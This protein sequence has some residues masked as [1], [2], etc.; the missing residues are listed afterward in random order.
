MFIALFIK[1]FNYRDFHLCNNAN[2][3]FYPSQ[4]NSIANIL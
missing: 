3:F 2:I 4:K 1:I